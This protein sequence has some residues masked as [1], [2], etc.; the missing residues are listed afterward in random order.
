MKRLPISACA[1]LL[2]VSLMACTGQSN[3]RVLVSAAAS[4]TD[5]FA[6]I[7]SVYEDIHPGVDVILNFGGSSALREQILE[8]A[9]VDVFASANRE[10]MDAIVESG[11]LDEDPVVFARNLLQI[12]VPV[13]NPGGVTGLTDFAN[14]ELLI[15]LC[16]AEVPCGHLARQVLAAADVTAAIDTNEPDVRSLLTKIEVGE[17]DAGIVYVTDVASTDGA[18]DGVDIPEEDNVVAEYPIAVIGESNPERA[19]DFVEFVLSDTGRA[20]LTDHGFSTP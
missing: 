16:A 6:E 17:L 19:A 12:A 7:E 9:P 15:G 18:V 2:L 1:P 13:G 11:L 5:V 10:N 20:I 14:E 4:L 3:P 8:G